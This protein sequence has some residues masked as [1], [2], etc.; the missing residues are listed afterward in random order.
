ML[1]FRVHDGSADTSLTDI[2]HYGERAPACYAPRD[3]FIRI[4]YSIERPD[5]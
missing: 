1:K 3:A 5:R 4:Q 2:E